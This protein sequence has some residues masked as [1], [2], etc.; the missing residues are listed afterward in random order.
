MKNM[1]QLPDK[2]NLVEFRWYDRLKTGRRVTK[3]EKVWRG[4]RS[5][6]GRPILHID[7]IVDET[8]LLEERVY[9]TPTNM[10][11]LTWQNATLQPRA[12]ICS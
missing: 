8:P 2:T 3:N 10:Q 9:S 6:C 12:E 7:L 11:Q 1:K 5:H 4:R